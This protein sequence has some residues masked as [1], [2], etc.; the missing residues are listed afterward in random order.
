MAMTRAE[1]ISMLI[2]A[3]CGVVCMAE[4]EGQDLLTVQYVNYLPGRM[5][6]WRR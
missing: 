5:H 2:N 1:C 4:G 6:S 3:Y